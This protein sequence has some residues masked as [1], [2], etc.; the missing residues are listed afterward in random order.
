M[1]TLF[2]GPWHVVLGHVNS[3]F[4][5][6]LV[7]SGSSSADGVYPVAFGAPLVLM[8]DGPRWQIEMQYFPFDE[9]ATWQPSDVRETRTFLPGDGLIVQL[10]G[11]A[12]PP[13]L[14]NPQYKN[15]A[16]TCTSLDPDVN[17]IPTANPYD[18]T[19]PERS[20][21]GRRHAHDDDWYASD[22]TGKGP[23]R[24]QQRNERD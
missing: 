24:A 6:R 5:Q 15:L 8:V 17:P 16:V 12:R 3:H 4:S 9:D 10:D 13:A 21:S 23:D 20:Y 22:E 14:V 2:Y 1:A 7:I 11:A 19:V 18:F